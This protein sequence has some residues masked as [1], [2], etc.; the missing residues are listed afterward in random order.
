MS[1]RARMRAV[2]VLPTPRTPVRIQ[3]C[4]IRPVSN[5][6]ETA[7]ESFETGV[8]PNVEGGVD[9][10]MTPRVLAMAR[11]LTQGDVG[12]MEDVGLLLELAERSGGAEGAS[13]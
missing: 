3:A 10:D 13:A 7:V 2:V 1:A 11:R 5:A 6:F 4:G 9:D 8:A 12:D